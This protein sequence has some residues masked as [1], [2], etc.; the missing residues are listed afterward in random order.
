MRRK[1][2]VMCG[3]KSWLGKWFSGLFWC[4]FCATAYADSGATFPR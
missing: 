2:C 3:E 4:H 1:T